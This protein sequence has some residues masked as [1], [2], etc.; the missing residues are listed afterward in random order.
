MPCGWWRKSS[1]RC[2]PSSTHGR[3][4]RSPPMLLQRLPGA[5][6][7]TPAEIWRV[8]APCCSFAPAQLAC[9]MPAASVLSEL[10]IV[11]LLWRASSISIIDPMADIFISYAMKDR[12]YAEELAN[13][14]D[15]IGLT[16]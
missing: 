9:G 3:A 14:L 7:G 15:E 12:P 16:T 13:F 1:N 6:R 10:K 11:I 2:R 5:A 4:F 8:A